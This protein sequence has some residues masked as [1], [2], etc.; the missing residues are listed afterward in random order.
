MV[1][2]CYMDDSGTDRDSAVVTVAGFLA[3]ME[4]WAEFESAAGHMFAGHGISLLH[5]VDLH[6][7]DGEFKGWTRKKKCE[8]CTELASL[9]RPFMPFGISVSAKK[10]VYRHRKA[11][12]DAWHNHSAFGTAFFQAMLITYGRIFYDLPGMMAHP[13]IDLSVIMEDGNKNNQDA[14]GVFNSLKHD[15]G[16]VKLAS[17]SFAG[18]KTCIAIQTADFLAFYSRRWMNECIAAD[19]KVQKPE[20]LQI[21][22]GQLEVYS[23]TLGDFLKL[24]NPGDALPGPEWRRVSYPPR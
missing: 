7:S 11:E 1:L 2:V 17:M 5:T 20:L 24:A 19:F 3:P 21:V 18:K 13:K 10:S 22:S 12:Y 6:A 16:L 14:L 4:S 9:M 15:K 23:E 8:F